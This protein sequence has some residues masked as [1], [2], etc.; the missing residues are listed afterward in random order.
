MTVIID[1]Q[2]YKAFEMFDRGP[3]K[4]VKGE[5]CSDET[6]ARGIKAA[7]AKQAMKQWLDSRGCELT[8]ERSK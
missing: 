6:V 1:G 4:I 2:V 3:W 7:S 8:Q 5:R